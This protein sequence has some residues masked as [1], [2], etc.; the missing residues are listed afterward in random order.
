MLSLTFVTVGAVSKLYV[1]LAVPYLI[2]APLG[3]DTDILQVS[4]LPSYVFDLSGAD[5][6]IVF[7][8][9]FA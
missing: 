8:V 3:D 9:H 1:P 7:S 5:T 2:V 4:A 6:L